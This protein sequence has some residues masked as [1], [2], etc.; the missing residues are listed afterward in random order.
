LDLH[1]DPGVKLGRVQNFRSWSPDMVK[2]GKTCLGLEY[3]VFEGDALWAMDDADLLEFATEE[4]ERIGLIP[5][6][7]VEAGT[8]SG[9]RRLS[10]LRLRLRGAHRDAAGVDAGTR[11]E[12]LP[13]RRN[14][15]HRYN[16]QD[17]SMLTAMLRSRTSWVA[18]TTSGRSTS[19]PTTTS[20]EL[21][22]QS[23]HELVA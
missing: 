22:A 14:G 6:G 4:I 9:S 21:H 5:K 17:H 2:T 10:G 12:R 16:N 15:M 11:S 13:R 23:W 8:S 7:I 19:K 3:F 18:T 1:H 20:Q